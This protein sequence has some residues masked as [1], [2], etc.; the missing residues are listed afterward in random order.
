MIAFLRHVGCPFAEHCVKRL[1]YWAD[2]HPDIEV[3]IV[4]HG[5]H[6]ASKR[7]LNSIGGQGRLH[8]IDDP[9]RELYGQ[10]GLGYSNLGHFMGLRSLLG[11]LRLLPRGIRNRQACG[12]RWQRSGL[13]LLKENRIIWYHI[14]HSAEILTLPQ[15]KLITG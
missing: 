5:D 15:G 14:P 8:L 13:F 4:S 3:S 9:E 11:V 7:W 6:K 1:R 12:T 2:E 10:W